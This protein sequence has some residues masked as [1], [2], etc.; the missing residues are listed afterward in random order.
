M[1]DAPDAHEDLEHAEHAAHAAREGG[2]AAA[3]IPLSITVMAVIAAVFG[4]LETT[5]ASTAVFARSDAAIRQGEASDLWGYYQARSIKKNMYEIAAAQSPASGGA[6][7]MKA[8]ADQYAAE[9][10][11]LQK[12]AQAKEEEVRHQESVS[13]AAMERHHH[14]TIATNIVHLAIALASIAIVM[15]R[16]WLWYGSLFVVVAGV[17]AVF[18]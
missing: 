5:S 10:A 4:S 15:R 16:R 18:V 8:K 14:L 2:L 6:P 12:K 11:D 1:S 17:A 9:E 3:A 7:D 13:E